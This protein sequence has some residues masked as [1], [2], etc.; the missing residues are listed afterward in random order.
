MVL[1]LRL[2]T[3][4]CYRGL[5]NPLRGLDADYAPRP[6]SADSPHPFPVTVHLL[7]EGIK[8]LRA[9]EGAAASKND[10]V[11]LWRGMRSLQVSDDFM[12]EGGSEK[13]PMS[14]TREL[15]VAVRYSASACSVLLKLETSNFRERGA[16]LSFLSAFPG[17][18]EVLYPPLTHLAPI[19]SQE[20]KTVE[21][22]SFTVIEVRPSLG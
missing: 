6:L 10:H 16:D 4:N 21:G 13:A 8:R 17:E 12:R 5:N 1:A 7:T 14:T 3:T 19:R 15:D 2:Y 20:V 9:V 11:V 18:A 22:V